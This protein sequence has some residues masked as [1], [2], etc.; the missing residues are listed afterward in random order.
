[1]GQVAAPLAPSGRCRAEKPN[2]GRRPACSEPFT[3]SNST[4]AMSPTSGSIFLPAGAVGRDLAARV[5]I[6]DDFRTDVRP[7]V[8]E[9]RLILASHALHF[10]HDICQAIQSDAEPLHDPPFASF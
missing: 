5:S 6:V 7:P 9:L 8:D 4:H 2:A 1:M 10:A 3:G